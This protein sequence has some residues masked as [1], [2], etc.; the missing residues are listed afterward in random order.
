M[1][2]CIY[3]ESVWS[4][5]QLRS[6]SQTSL[7]MHYS[8]VKWRALR[9]EAPG[10]RLRLVSVLHTS[11]HVFRIWLHLKKIY[12]F[13]IIIINHHFLIHLIHLEF[14]ISWFT[15]LLPIWFIL[16]SR[17]RSTHWRWRTWPLLCLSM[18]SM[19]KNLITSHKKNN[20][21]LK[22]TSESITAP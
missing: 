21:N 5:W 13:W 1:I 2:F 16:K 9:L 7:M 6:L 17:I 14:F 18:A 19:L 4:L 10:A 8:T 15:N 22:G 11:G 3:T 12:N 20:N